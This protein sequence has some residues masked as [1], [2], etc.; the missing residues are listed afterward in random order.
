[1]KNETEKQLTEQERQE[2]K[3]WREL[4]EFANNSISEADISIDYKDF[5]EEGKKLFDVKLKLH[6]SEF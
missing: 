3:A 5:I 4:W 6:T 1:M 2:I